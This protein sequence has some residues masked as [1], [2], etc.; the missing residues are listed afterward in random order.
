[1]RWRVVADLTR[2]RVCMV[3]SG[4]GGE[5]FIALEMWRYWFGKKCS[6]CDYLWNGKAPFLF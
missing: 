3:G 1:M 5:G 2:G 4:Y 6:A